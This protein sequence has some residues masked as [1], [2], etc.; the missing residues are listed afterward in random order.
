MSETQKPGQPNQN[1]PEDL[2]LD[3]RPKESYMIGPDGKLIDPLTAFK[4]PDQD[5]ERSRAY[6]DTLLK[7]KPGELVRLS[8]IDFRNYCTLMFT[9][10]GHVAKLG[11]ELVKSDEELHEILIDVQKLIFT[12]HQHVMKAEME[13]AQ[14]VDKIDLKIEEKTKVIEQNFANMT[15]DFKE[16]LTKLRAENQALK[17]KF[18]NL[19]GVGST[20][21]MKQATRT[22]G[23]GE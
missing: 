11:S 15:A 3:M 6:T 5:I 12:L 14:V 19:E 16:E 13:F 22:K 7:T 9:R 10:L 20:G 21:V 1:I 2:V 4:R 17:D 23:P 18:A 8:E